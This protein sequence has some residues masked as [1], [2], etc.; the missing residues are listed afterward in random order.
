MYIR[1]IIKG[2]ETADIRSAFYYTS[3]YIKQ[4][5]YFDEYSKDI[6]ADEKRSAPNDIVRELTLE[7]IRAIEHEEGARAASFV[8]EIAFRIIREI[9]SV[10]DTLSVEF[11][12]EELAHA[13]NF[14]ASI[15]VPFLKS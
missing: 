9:T 12:D 4:A 7:L 14:V 15:D 6:F 10:E 8:K 2:Y 1:E 3:R 5:E 11:S 13:S